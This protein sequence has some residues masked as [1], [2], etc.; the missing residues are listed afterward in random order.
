MLIS[1][2]KCKLYNKLNF[3]PKAFFFKEKV[4]RRVKPIVSY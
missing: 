2:V 1:W 4:W 3:I